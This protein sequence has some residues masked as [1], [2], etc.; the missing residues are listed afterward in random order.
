MCMLS[1]RRLSAY[2]I[3]LPEEIQHDKFAMIAAEQGML[4]PG[5]G[6]DGADDFKRST[7]S[8]QPLTD[9]ATNR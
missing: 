2:V 9:T 4:F 8:L 5:E 3:P 6:N 1:H 7:F